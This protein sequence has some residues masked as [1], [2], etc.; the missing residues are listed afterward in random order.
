MDISV[1]IFLS[2]GLFLGWSLGAND[3]SNVFGTAVASK[4]ITFTTA[5]VIC[6]V[7]IILGAVFC[8]AGAAHGLGALGSLNTLPGAF[9]AAFSAA[10]TVLWMT[11]LGLPVSTTQA[12]VGA[13]I[14]W[15]F[16]SGSIT[17]VAVLSKIVATWVACPLLGALFGALLYKLMVAVVY[18]TKV[19]LLSLDSYTRWGLI[20]AGAFGSYSLGANNI[21]NV[22]GVFV[23]S[24]P[25]TDIEIGD[26]YTFSSV[27]QLFLVGA[28]AI[29]VGVFTYSKKVM[30]TVGNSLMPLNAQ[31]AWVVVVAHSLV[32]FL[33]S[34]VSLEHFLSSSG[35]PTIPLIPVS[36]SQAVVGAVIGIALLQGKKGIRSVRWKVLL[37]I[38]SGWVTTPIIAAVMCFFM[39]FVLQNVFDQK[40]YAQTYYRLSPPVLEHLQQAGIEIDDL[41]ALSGDTIA[42]GKAFQK[43]LQADGKISAEALTL[44]SKSAEI[45]LTEIDPIALKKL[46]RDNRGYLEDAQISAIESI[47]GQKFSYKWQLDDALASASSSWQLKEKTKVNKIYNSE[48]E[49]RLSAVREAFHVHDSPQ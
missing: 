33:F 42:S 40:V 14:G 31:G 36:S 13:I 32:L 5:A 41:E 21:G 17:D 46:K 7:F 25:F 28:L 8:G 48:V 10:L 47:A 27:Q 39:L 45:Y 22:M 9:M 12:I 43:A 35:L 11:R 23:S 4:M 16:F 19:H 26:L 38:A 3:A 37:N 44:I 2:S 15:N 20:L 18:K 34:S 24:S 1:L 29:G 30:M 49:T 6:S